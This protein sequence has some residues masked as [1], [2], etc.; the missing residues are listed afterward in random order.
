MPIS[1]KLPG[2]STASVSAERFCFLGVAEQTLD[3]RAEA[4]EICRIVDQEPVLTARDLVGDPANRGSHDWT[5]LPHPLGD[6]EAEALREA[7]L[8]DHRRVSLQRVDDGSCLLG[9]APASATPGTP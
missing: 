1:E 8:D 5:T 7:L 9:Y 2:R 4:L 3:R 6:S